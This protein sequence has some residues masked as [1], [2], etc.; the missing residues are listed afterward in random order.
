ME[1]QKNIEKSEKKE[2][3]NQL[4]TIKVIRPKLYIPSVERYMFK[5]EYEN[6]VLRNF[7][8]KINDPLGYMPNIMAD[9]FYGDTRS[10][11]VSKLSELVSKDIKNV[12]N[13]TH[14]RR[15]NMEIVKYLKIQKLQTEQ[16]IRTFYFVKKNLCPS[17]ETKKFSYLCCDYVRRKRSVIDLLL[18]I[19]ERMSQ[20]CLKG[21]EAWNFLIRAYSIANSNKVKKSKK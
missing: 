20:V 5:P 18:K 8:K 2:E 7:E 9:A 17:L 3:I 4:Q 14:V 16:I 6:C 19:Q 1:I 21:E 12:L 10:R 13:C 11:E 15:M